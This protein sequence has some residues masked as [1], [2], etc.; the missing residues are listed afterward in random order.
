[1]KDRQYVHSY[2]KN[3]PSQNRPERYLVKKNSGNIVSLA[4][5]YSPPPSAVLEVGCNVGRNL[6]NLWSNGYRDLSGVEINPDA[7]KVMRSSYPEL[8]T[9]TAYPGQVEEI[10]LKLPDGGY[11]LIFSMAVLCHI[12][13]D[14]EFIFGEM[15]RCTKKYIITIEDEVCRTSRHCPRS[16]DSVF[17]PLGMK[18]LEVRHNL[19]GMNQNYIARV[20]E[21]EKIK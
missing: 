1:M 2:W 4:L 8:D 21:K 15:V 6:F 10:I 3:P 19:E 20:F 12:H 9:A 17:V 14:S 7:L 11:D 13:P 18:E 5:K 16:Y